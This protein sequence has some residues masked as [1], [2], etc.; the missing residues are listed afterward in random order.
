MSA[1]SSRWSPLVVGVVLLLLPCCRLLALQDPAF[2]P[3]QLLLALAGLLFSCYF[4]FRKPGKELDGLLHP[5]YLLS[6]LQFLWMML[7]LR[8]S[9]IA[10]EGIL[11]LLR[12][13]IYAGWTIL[14]VAAL[15]LL[16]DPMRIVSRIALFTVLLCLI[17]M[18]IQVVEAMNHPKG[19]F[20]DYHLSSFFGNKNYYSGVLILLLPFTLAQ[21]T[22]ERSGWRT[23]GRV[24]VVLVVLQLLLL[25]SVA[26]WIALLAMALVSVLLPGGVAGRLKLVRWSAGVVG[27]LIAGVFAISSYSNYDELLIG[28]V[29]DLRQGGSIAERIAEADLRNENSLFERELM[30]R[31]AWLQFRDHPAFGAG[32]SNYR[33]LQAQYGVGGTPHLN[34]G[35]VRFEHPHNEYLL[36]L[37]EQGLPG[38]LL[39]LA[40]I[41]A[42]L[43]P[44]WRLMKDDQATSPARQAARWSVTGVAGFLVLSMLAYPALRPMERMLFQL[45]AAI[46]IVVVPRTIG[47]NLS[48]K[49]GRRGWWL[50]AL[51]FLGS[52]GVL[53]QRLGS[54]LH[55]FQSLVW[56]AKRQP[57]RQIREVRKAAGYWMQVD[58][59]TTPLI[60]YEGTHAFYRG[61]VAKALPYFERSAQLSPWHLR[62][63]NDLGTC[64][65]QLG[66]RDSAVSLYERGLRITPHFVEGRLN[67]A[68]AWFNAGRAWQAAATL[69]KLDPA[70]LRKAE[71]EKYTTYARV[72]LSAIA[73]SDMNAV[74][75][76]A[77][78]FPWI[79]G[80][81]GWQ[82]VLIGSKG[83]SAN[84]KRAIESAWKQAE[85]RQ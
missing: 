4:S 60:W 61:E 59:T 79:E 55:F 25:Q 18:V 82:E 28:K 57:E 10:G 8:T 77:R 29:K 30:F 62:V 66:K 45:H 78:Y 24:A 11:D 38:L 42:L 39:W 16:P 19:F 73:R 50:L 15:R 75:D 56:Q 54:E 47:T 1:V 34:S 7:S 41:T 65:E 53:W 35:H 3:P 80:F 40:M 37:A 74:R 20:V 36:L 33:M 17:P 43:V 6:A 67:L 85:A 51:F 27:V 76:T 68:A 14:L 64:Y 70:T 32:V 23:A 84:L 71:R 63:I 9:W 22:T 31:N 44:A 12:F 2:T 52:F 13:G 81:Q 21:A 49:A 46:L 48:L 5:W 69:E 72:I 58:F 83:D 26:A